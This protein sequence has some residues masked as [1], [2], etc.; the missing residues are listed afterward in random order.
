[1]ERARALL[2]G[3]LRPAR[4]RLADVLEAVS[5]ID[6]AVVDAALASARW[7]WTLDATTMALDYV[8]P[9]PGDRPTSWHA[10]AGRD[11]LRDSREAWEM[12]AGR[13]VIPE[14]WVGTTARRFESGMYAAAPPSMQGVLSIFP[15]YTSDAAHE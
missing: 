13:G 4:P 14:D 15:L 5:G 8:A 9:G 6:R 1:M 12:L 11:R 2:F 7:R 3:G 10:K